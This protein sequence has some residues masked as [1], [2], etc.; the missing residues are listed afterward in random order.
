MQPCYGITE[1]RLTA[2]YSE[3]RA[4][5]VGPVE[6][7]PFTKAVLCLSGLRYAFSYY[8]AAHSGSEFETLYSPAHRPDDGLHE[9]ACIVV[10]RL[11]RG[12]RSR[13]IT[14]ALAP[15]NQQG[16]VNEEWLRWQLAWLSSHEMGGG[17]VQDWLTRTGAPEG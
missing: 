6:E 5:G 2:Y 9:T 4:I 15:A 17:R 7:G 11:T 12:A 13:T 1:T 8:K 3:L 10:K 14:S 16:S